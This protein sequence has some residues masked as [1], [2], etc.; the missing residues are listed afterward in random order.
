M[1]GNFEGIELEEIEKN[2]RGI[3]PSP[4][5]RF[6]SDGIQRLDILIS[7]RL[8]VTRAFAQKLIE[9]GRVKTDGGDLS[10]KI[11][12]S[13][14]IAAGEGILVSLPPPETLEIQ[15]E[16]V[17]F[18]VVY[19]DS[20]LLVLNKPAGLVVH[21]APGHWK[22]TLVHGLLFR[23]PD[24]GP[25]NNVI[26]PGIVHRLD[27]TTSGLMLV[28]RQQKTMESL[29]RA[30]KTRDVDKHYLALV[31]NLFKQPRG[32]LE[33]P[34]GRHPQNRL[35]MAVVQ[36]GRPSAT[37]Y[38][39]L[40]NRHDRA[41]VVCRLL[42]G[43]TH[44]IRVHMAAAGHPIVGDVLYGGKELPNFNRVFLHSWKLA[45]THPDTHRAM[46]FTCP[47]PDDLKLPLENLNNED[48][49]PS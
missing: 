48:T 32:T 49:F 24:L 42:T 21:P 12:P 4:P 47:L 11:K 1:R 22:S 43:R 30:F 9:E 15:P 28:A 34:I 26:R 25:F 35:K 36:G 3:F 18:Q 8:G 20:C 44:Q 13:R 33:G 17:P 45:F 37:E 31:H 29:Q 40:W 14:K 46:T 10:H 39:V 38:R 27:A 41:F 2:G 6:A 19:E 5:E 23:Y 7:Q 16:D